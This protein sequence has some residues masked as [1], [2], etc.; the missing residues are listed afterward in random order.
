[1]QVR[2]KRAK[3]L[4]GILVVVFGIVA[5]RVVANIV[6]RSNQ[7]KNSRQG[8]VAVVTADYPKR[9]T[10]VPKFRFSGT[11]D[12]VWQADVAAKVDGRIE[13]VLV[14]EGQAVAA[15]QP[16]AILEQADTSANLLNARGLYLDAKTNYEKAQTD[17]QRYEALYARGAISKE[18][19]DNMRFALENARGKLNAAQ[20]NLKL[21]E[22][23]NGGTTVLTPRAGIIQKRYYQEGYYAKTGTALFNIADISTLRAKINVPEGYVSSIEPGGTVDFVIES[24]K[25]NDKHV[26]GTITHISPVAEGASRTFEAEVSVDNGDGR[27]R[28]GVYADTTITAVPKEN[29]LTVPL[30]A[31]VMRDDQ[32]TVYIIQDGHA[33]RRV[34][35]TGYIGDNLVEILDGVTEQDLVITGGQNKIREGSSVKVSG[36]KE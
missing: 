35:K 11:L 27:L 25:G 30:S 33:V 5:F 10:I 36:E 31:I 26:A 17:L 4:I 18:T 7:A 32:R 34:I 1:M 29:A 12:P 13:R 14:E 8:K 16:L 19:L 9:Q 28:G 23:E 22:S 6:A 21:R 15:G 2:D 3:I 24:M 20:G